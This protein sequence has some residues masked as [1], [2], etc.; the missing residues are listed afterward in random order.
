MFKIPAVSQ[1]KPLL[2]IAF[3]FYIFGN[4]CRCFCSFVFPHG[5][6]LCS[7]LAH[8][9]FCCTVSSGVSPLISCHITYS[10]RGSVDV[11]CHR[12]R[13]SHSWTEKPRVNKP[14]RGKK[15]HWRI[16]CFPSR[17]LLILTFSPWYS[18]ENK[19]E[20]KKSKNDPG[21]CTFKRIKLP[22]T[23]T[24]VRSASKQRC[25]VVFKHT[26]RIQE[27]LTGVIP[28]ISVL[29]A[30]VRQNQSHLSGTE[31]EEECTCDKK[32]TTLKCYSHPEHTRLYDDEALA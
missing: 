25:H 13:L 10:N 23:Y 17:D 29:S 32:H 16:A 26:P 6:W 1:K 4:H 2:F 28:A 11:T 21:S 15:W 30:A 7:T 24:F 18:S 22:S 14:V 31:S 3:F 12:N 27:L 19:P 8:V 20:A 9:T 5:V